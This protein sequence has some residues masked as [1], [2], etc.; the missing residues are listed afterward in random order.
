M[1]QIKYIVIHC[2]AGRAQQKTSDI[3]AYWRL[4]L[5]WKSFGYHWI[6]GEDGTKERLTEDYAPTNGVK[7]FNANSIHLC[8]KGGWDGTDTRTD[9]QKKSLLE[10][11]QHYKKLYPNALVV[12]HRDLSPD[13][14]KDGKITP[15]EWVKKCPCFSPIEEYANI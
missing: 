15:N 3:I 12:G 9:A 4:K 7:G 13:L 5:G 6:V 11:V 2:T 1:R 10:L 8:Y 14:N